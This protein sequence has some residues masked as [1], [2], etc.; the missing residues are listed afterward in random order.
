VDV[1]GRDADAVAAEISE[2]LERSTY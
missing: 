2:W 1:D